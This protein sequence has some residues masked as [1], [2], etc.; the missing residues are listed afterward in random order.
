MC[1]APPEDL[2]EILELFDRI[3]VMS[4]GKIAYLT[5]AASAPTARP[6]GATWPVIEARGRRP[7]L[8]FPFDP[9]R[10]AR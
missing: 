10:T 5:D 1:A 3:A 2:D 7:P 8:A 6:S 9:D 4:G